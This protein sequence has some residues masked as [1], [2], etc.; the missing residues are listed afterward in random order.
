MNDHTT[1]RL[2]WLNAIDREQPT[3]GL[4]VLSGVRVLRL[5]TASARHGSYSHHSYIFSH[6]GVLFAAW[7]NHAV[8]EDAS[9]QRALWSRSNDGG[10]SWTDW[11]E[12]FPPQ[13]KVK[14]HAEQDLLNDRVLIPN[15]F[16]LVGKDLYAVA[17][18][19]VL[20]DHRRGFGRLAR[21]IHGDG[22]CDPIFWLV[23]FPPEPKAGFPAY[24]PASD[25]AIAPLAA[26]IHQCLVRPGFEPSWEFQHQTCNPQAVDGHRLCEPTQSWKLASGTWVRL[27]RDKDRSSN[28]NY[29]RFSTDDGLTW[30]PPVRTDFPDASSRSAVGQLPDGTALVINNPGRERSRVD[31]GLRRDPLVLSLAAD[32]LTFDRSV[33]IAHSAPPPAFEGYAKNPGYQYPRAVVLGE[34]LFAM[35]SVNKEH[36]EV[37]TIPLASLP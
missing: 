12:L 14:P 34:S 9:G 33:V 24:P 37:A 21:R 7:S 30:A 5:Y 36:I 18:V 3:L 15:G 6:Q 26:A 17:E 11:E 29:A 8:D 27:Y 31:G 2:R 22:R 25:P 13:D 1:P 10:R 23:D 20:G 32:G 4:P 28:V 16:A 19:H 35:Y